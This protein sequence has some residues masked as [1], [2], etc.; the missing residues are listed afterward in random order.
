MSSYIFYFILILVLILRIPLTFIFIILRNI[1]PAI[2]K[3]LDFERLNLMG[4]SHQSFNRNN[5]KAKVLFHVS[6]EGELEQAW[7]LIANYLN[8]N[9]PIELVYTSDSVEKKCHGLAQKHPSLIRI[10]RLP[11][12]SFFPFSFLYFQS[13]WQWATA[14]IIVMCRYDFFP[15]LLAFKLFNKKMVLISGTTKKISRL[16]KVIFQQF[17]YIIAANELE[18]S[19]FSYFFEKQIDAYDFRIPRIFE[20][21]SLKEQALEKFNQVT[22]FINTLKED[23]SSKIIMGSLWNSDVAIFNNDEFINQIKKG[24]IK[25]IIAPHKLNA[26]YINSLFSNLEKYFDRSLIEIVGEGAISSLRPISIISYPGVLC[27]MYSLFE[28]AYVGCG[29]EKSVHSV[30]EP[31]LMG[32]KVICGPKVHRSTEVDFLLEQSP[33]ELKILNHPD[34]FY[35]QYKELLKTQGHLENRIRLKNQMN[36]K[37]EVMAKRILS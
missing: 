26:D 29:F 17:D 19:N 18:K 11:L 35:N 12:L 25:V 15:E 14:D 36:E 32:C 13:I 21:A 1:S 22:N 7:A 28:I 9:L 23:H 27:E 34:L 37:V 16:K 2:K 6:S 10:C 24:Q 30:L 4:V 8:L 31:Y 20:R 3:R 33:V 5:V